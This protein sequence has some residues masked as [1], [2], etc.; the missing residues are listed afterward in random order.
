M[1]FLDESFSVLKK[2]LNYSLYQ[3][4]LIADNIA[5]VSTVNYKR[6]D[7]D[8]KGLL[9]SSMENSLL[10]AR[11][12]EGHISLTPEDTLNASL[13]VTQPNVTDVNDDNNNVDLDKEIVNMSNNSIYYNSLATLVNFKLRMLKEVIS[14]RIS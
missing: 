6:K 12:H 9:Q 3:H 13:F 7:L 4:D 11:T 8:F 2:G 14:E 10:A 1:M 5:N